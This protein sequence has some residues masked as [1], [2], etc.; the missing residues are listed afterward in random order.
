MIEVD[1]FGEHQ[2][3]QT[4]S[5]QESSLDLLNSNWQVLDELGGVGGGGGGGGGLVCMLPSCIVNKHT[6]QY[7]TDGAQ[8]KGIK[9]RQDPTL[10]SSN[11]ISFNMCIRESNKDGQMIL[12]GLIH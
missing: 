5:L 6:I 3:R 2:Y 1:L 4:A 11:R 8:K 10:Y 12:I 7:N 9:N